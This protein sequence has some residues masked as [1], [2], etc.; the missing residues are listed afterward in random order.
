MKKESDA[1]TN[2]KQEM[3]KKPRKI[4]IK[5]RSDVY[6]HCETRILGMKQ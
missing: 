5:V 3:G 2:V 6:K 1:S 4:F